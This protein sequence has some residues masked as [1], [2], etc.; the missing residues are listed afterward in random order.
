MIKTKVNLRSLFN[1]PCFLCRSEPPNSSGLCEECHA[2]LPW[3]ISYCPCC[4]EPRSAEVPLDQPC[5]RCQTNPPR[6]DRVI[7]AF[8]YAFPLRQMIHGIKYQ[9]RP[10]LIGGL[11]ATLAGLIEERCDPLPELILPVP[12][13]PWH[14]TL[15]GFNQAALLAEE[16]GKRLGIPVNHRVLRKLHRTRHQANLDRSTRATNLRGSFRVH[17][18][19]PDRIAIVDDILTTGATA[20]ELARCAKRAGAKEVDIWVLARTPSN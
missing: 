6:F 19:L 10:A 3:L 4:A 20:N 11:A 15:R 18:E 16:L 2:D 9:R 1:Q 7:A 8:G 12:M 14:E 13:H 17:G 5:G